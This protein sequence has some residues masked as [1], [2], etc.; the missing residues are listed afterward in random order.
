MVIAVILIVVI[1]VGILYYQGYL[2]RF[3]LILSEEGSRIEYS[4]PGEGS[5]K[6]ITSLKDIAVAQN[7]YKGEYGTYAPFMELL[8]GDGYVNGEIGTATNPMLA[9]EGYYFIGLAK[10]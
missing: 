10:Q 7:K 9:F 2:G 6:V 8:L 1:A 3:T 4:R 5:K